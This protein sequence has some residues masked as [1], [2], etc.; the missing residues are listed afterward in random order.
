MGVELLKRGQIAVTAGDT[1][2]PR[3]GHRRIGLGGS[4]KLRQRR[5][6]SLA[7]LDRHRPIEMP[8]R[9]E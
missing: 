4:H 1:T 7:I 2:Q 3:V 5:H 9:S 8:A 6:A